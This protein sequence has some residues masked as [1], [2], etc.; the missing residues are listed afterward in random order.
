[1]VQLSQFLDMHFHNAEL[2]TYV[3]QFFLKSSYYENI[4]ELTTKIDRRY[5][6][7]QS[8]QKING[9]SMNFFIANRS[10]KDLGPR[11]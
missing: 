7:G 6:I 2:P 5:K 11:T 4:L 3:V 9:I 8:R 1:M 10:A